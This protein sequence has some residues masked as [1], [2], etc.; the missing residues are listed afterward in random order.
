MIC[1]RLSLDTKPLKDLV[2]T[3]FDEVKTRKN[4]ALF[5]YTERFDH[6]RLDTLTVMPEEFVQAEAVLGDDLKKSIS[7]AFDNIY[8]F[9]AAQ[10]E[11]S[12]PIE[13]MPGV[14]CW[15]KSVPIDR[16]GFYIPGGSA[17]LFST[18]LMLGIPA[19][20]A[21]CKTKVLCSPPGLDGKIDPTILYAAA[22]VGVDKVY[23]VGGIQAIAAMTLSTETI[24][25]VYKIFGPGNQYV[26]AAKDYSQSYS[27]A[28]DLPAGPSEVLVI[29]DGICDPAFVAAD[30]LAQAEH[31]PDSQVVLVS[32]SKDYI[33]QVQREIERLVPILSRSKVI[34]QSLSTSSFSVLLKD[35]EE[36]MAFA[37]EYAPEHLILAIDH[38]AYY[39]DQVVNAGSV[40]VGGYS[41]ESFGDY[42]S[43]TNHTL[44]TSGYAKAYS[45]VSLDSF[46]KKITFQE[47]TQEGLK[48]LGPTVMTMAEAEGL[49]AHK[50][51][52]SVRLNLFKD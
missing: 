40:F 33:D 31:G 49:D 38:A 41:C 17:P 22:L 24:P 37:N 45:G 4:Q 9:H 19:L 2:E 50:N 25:K 20:I 6:C 18:V 35:L 23:K 21:G 16:V 1:E 10:Q 43:G 34:N 8:K 12:N 39:A 52:I 15:R 7:I 30:L 48:L 42:A 32:T 29:A 28:I 26:M 5:D 3:I 44:P 14:N 27:V 51:A 13:V 11:T 36:C 46:V 47:I